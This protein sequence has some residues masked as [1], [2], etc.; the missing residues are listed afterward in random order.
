M[1][2]PTTVQTKPP[3]PLRGGYA[4]SNYWNHLTQ[5]RGH[6]PGVGRAMNIV[7]VVLVNILRLFYC[8]LKLVSKH[9]GLRKEKRKVRGDEW[10]TYTVH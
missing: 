2:H 8:A 1:Y 5:C 10:N 9:R 7:V 4:L 3:R 6:R